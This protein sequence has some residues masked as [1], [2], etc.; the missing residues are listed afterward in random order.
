M[1]LV[2]EDGSF[3][4]DG[5]AEG[6]YFEY[7]TGAVYFPPLG[8]FTLNRPGAPVACCIH[9]AAC[10]KLTTFSSPQPSARVIAGFGSSGHYLG[11][12]NAFGMLADNDSYRPERGHHRHRT[13]DTLANEAR[14]TIVATVFGLKCD[15][16]NAEPRVLNGDR[17]SRN[18]AAV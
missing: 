6:N 10:D 16:C 8:N 13:Q 12:M 1:R 9:G 4:D 2:I 5:L 3:L 14:C 11:R 18:P 7:V 17:R 15:C